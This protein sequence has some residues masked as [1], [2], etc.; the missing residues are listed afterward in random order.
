[1]RDIAEYIIQHK[2]GLWGELSSRIVMKEP[3][4]DFREALLGELALV[5]AKAMSMS[6]EEVRSSIDYPL[7]ER[8]WGMGFEKD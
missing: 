5:V 8:L 3:Q 2:E 1:V 7:V 6:Y 4:S